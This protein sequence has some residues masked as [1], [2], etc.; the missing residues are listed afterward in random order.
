MITLKFDF[1]ERQKKNIE[2]LKNSEWLKEKGFP[3]IEKIWHIGFEY[4]IEPTEEDY[5]EFRKAYDLPED[6]PI[7]DDDYDFIIFLE[8]KYEEQAYEEYEREHI[9]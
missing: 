1:I 5:I 2:K 6:E 3:I 8:E 7:S 9:L 4:D